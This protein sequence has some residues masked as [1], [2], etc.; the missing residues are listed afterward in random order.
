MARETCS[1]RSLRTAKS[2]WALTKSVSSSRARFTAVFCRVER[3]FTGPA[4]IQARLP[5]SSS[6]GVGEP[7]SMRP[8]GNSCLTWSTFLR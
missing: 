1:P 2:S 5:A 3:L 4:F 8:A 6:G 7:G